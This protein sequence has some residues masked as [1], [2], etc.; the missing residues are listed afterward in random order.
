MPGDVS[1]TLRSRARPPDR[2]FLRLKEE[3]TMA[4]DVMGTIKGSL[5][6]G[7]FPEG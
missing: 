6:E 3:G 2:I 5:L 4:I 7:F 1:S